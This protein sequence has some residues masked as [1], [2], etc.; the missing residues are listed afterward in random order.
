MGARVLLQFNRRCVACTAP[1]IGPVKKKNLEW[2]HV[3][4]IEIIVICIDIDIYI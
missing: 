1:V 4:I 2:T 3:S